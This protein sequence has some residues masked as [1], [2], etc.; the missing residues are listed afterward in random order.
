MHTKWLPVYELY[1][2]QHDLV[3]IMIERFEMASHP[4]GQKII[5][6]RA[7]FGRTFGP[8][9]EKSLTEFMDNIFSFL[10]E[11]SKKNSDLA[12]E[13]LQ[14]FREIELEIEKALERCGD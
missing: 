3:P 4:A 1:L 6:A 12:E 11:A 9:D 8:E 5:A 10:A 7:K 2:Y 14:K 13:Y